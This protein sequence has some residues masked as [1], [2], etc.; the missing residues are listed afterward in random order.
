MGRG[1]EQ[2]RLADELW[3]D[4][5]LEFLEGLRKGLPT[6]GNESFEAALEV[7]PTDAE[8]AA[9]V[10]TLCVMRGCP[11]EAEKYYEAAI[12]ADPSFSYPYLE[13]VLF[14]EARGRRN[15]A[16]KVAVRAIKAGARWTDEWQR[17]PHHVPSLI[18]KAWWSPQ[19]FPWISQLE[20]FFPE[21]KAELAT[22]LEA[23]GSMRESM[24]RHWLQVGVQRANQDG[25]IVKTGGEWREFVVFG[26]ED[27]SSSST[28]AAQHLPRTRAILEE[29][30]PGAVQMAKLGAGEIIFS[31]IAPHTHLMPHCASSN[32]R[33]TCHLGMVCPEGARV[34]VGD[35]WGSWEEGKCIVFD[36]SYE[37]EVVHEGDAMRIVLLIRFW[38]PMLPESEWLPTLN[39]GLEEYN[40]LGHRRKMPP[41]SQEIQQLLARKLQSATSQTV[42]TEPAAKQALEKDELF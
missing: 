4:G 34:R 6:E 20:S 40:S 9:F 15:D 17:P 7:D 30:A 37:H 42:A 8:R 33:L 28:P 29:I 31:A 16:R 38:H 19:D 1:D 3:T 36:D 39:A 24:P 14:L 35:Q 32:V 18:S 21:I 11:D 23:S 41:I 5:V 27:E 13:L 10:G 2:R 25:D 26:V 22:L 12:Q